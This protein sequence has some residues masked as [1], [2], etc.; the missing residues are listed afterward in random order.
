MKNNTYWK[1]RFEELEQF[2]HQIGAAF[3]QTI[4][5]QY[6]QAQKTIDNKIRSWYQRFAINNQVSM[7]EARKL[8]TSKELKEFKWDVQDYIKYGE[9]NALNAIWMKELENASARY[10]ISRL[11]AL[12]LQTQQSMEVLFGHQTVGIDSLVKQIYSNSYYH[13]AFEIQKGFGFGWRIP[14]LDQSKIEKVILKPWATDGSNFSDRIWKN[15][16]KLINELHT[17][18]TQ[19]CILGTSPDNAIKNITKKMDVSK[20]NA[21]NLVMTES[22]AFAS[23]AQKKIF[24]DL[25]V[26][27]FQVVE[28]LDSK[29]C[30]E[31]GNM[32]SRHFPIS[33]F[34]VGMTAPPFHPR[35]RGCTC[36][37]F[38]DEF[39]IGERVARD[40]EGNTYYIPKNM[41]YNKW[42]SKYVA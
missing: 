12:K 37:Y 17:E 9:E 21:G 31:C 4:E 1:Y 24:S 10:H 6:Y 42:I 2:T 5:S 22:A 18:M 19:M 34:S 14:S 27:E 29:T 33:E 35:C 23:I 41:S 38:D 36:P 25:G 26:E 20:V 7:E 8:L 3:C 28:T 15:K 30:A 32:D 39:S 13:S 11:E 16:T 40:K